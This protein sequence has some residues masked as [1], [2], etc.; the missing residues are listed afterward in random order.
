MFFP[1]IL[2]ALFGLVLLIVSVR[3]EDGTGDMKPWIVLGALCLGG[4]VL[5]VGLWLFFFRE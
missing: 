5:L 2:L 1:A 4:G 3:M